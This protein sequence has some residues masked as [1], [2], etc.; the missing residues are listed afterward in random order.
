[1]RRAFNKLGSIEID[2]S[3][4]KYRISVQDLGLEDPLELEKEVKRKLLTVEDEN[5]FLVPFSIEV[6]N[7]YM[8][9]YYNLTHFKALDYLRELELE[10]KIPYFLSL[11]NIAKEQEKGL[12]ISWDRANFV[13]DKYDEKVKVFL[14]E[15]ESITIY[16]SPVDLLKTVNDLIC[17]TMTSLSSFI[18]LPKRQDFIDPSE[19]NILFIENIY[20]MNNLD[21]L[22]MY[23]ETLSLDLEHDDSSTIDREEKVEKKQ[24]SLFQTFDKKVASKPKKKN[25]SKPRNGTKKKN[26]DDKNMKLGFI[27]VGAALVLYLL[28]GLIGPSPEAK[29]EKEIVKIESSNES[30]FFKGT[31]KD[32]IN[33]V[34]AYRKAYNSDYEE[35]YLSLSKIEKADLDL[36]DVPLLIEVYD[37]TDNL[38]L[39]LDD[40][41]SLANSVVTY[42]LTRNKLD[43]LTAIASQMNTKNPYIE[44]EKAHYNQEHEYMLSLINDIEINGRKESQIMDAYL[45]L[46]LID[47]ARKFAEKVGNPD[48]IKR[49]E[50]T[51]K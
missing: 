49:V 39:L 5:N 20:R 44:F 48:L 34:E 14:F 38:S 16:D 21:D 6:M 12:N 33:L 41:P 13:C 46:Q 8:I 47:E 32:S 29:E 28:N 22:Y 40:V 15:T 11:I 19:E 35:S 24:V 45:D 9:M 43:K 18:T 23:L 26:K 30:S 3:T 27:F 17:S 2:A 7:R 51:R 1:M 37:Q 25:V 10:E 4:L 42:L 31:A 50:E 36:K